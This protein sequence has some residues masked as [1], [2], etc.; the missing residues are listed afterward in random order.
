MMEF[1]AYRILY[2]LFANSTSDLTRLMAELKP[3]TWRDP[4][5]AHALDVREAMALNDYRNFLR[6][7]ARVPNMGAYIMDLFVDKVRLSTLKIMCKAYRPTVLVEF[8]Q[9]GLGFDDAVDCVLFLKEHSAVFSSDQ[10]SID[11]RST[12]S[13]LS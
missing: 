1:L 13:L 6:L 7:Y 8:L 2:Y 5:V 4:A 11:T 3:H 12:F 9:K 10:Q